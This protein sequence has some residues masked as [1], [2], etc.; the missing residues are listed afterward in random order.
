MEMRKTKSSSSKEVPQKLSV[1]QL[2]DQVINEMML[3]KY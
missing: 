1:S 2:N 3:K